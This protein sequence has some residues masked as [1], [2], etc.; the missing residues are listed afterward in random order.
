MAFA[1]EDKRSIAG[2]GIDITKMEIS[3]YV[4]KKYAGRDA[5]ARCVEGLSFIE[6]VWQ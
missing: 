5:T 2:G 3:R 4:V 1:G 6:N